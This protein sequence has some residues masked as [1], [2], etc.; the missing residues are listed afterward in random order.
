MVE[1]NWRVSRVTI[2]DK[3]LQLLLPKEVNP[4]SS[5]AKRSKTTGHLVVTMPLAGEV[6]KAAPRATAP[7][8]KFKSRL[9][10]KPAKT[11]RKE[12]E[13]E[14]LDIPDDAATKDLD[15][16]SI[17]DKD[18]PQNRGIYKRATAKVLEVEAGKNIFV[19][20]DLEKKTS[21]RKNSEGFVDNPDVP[22]LV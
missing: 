6:V 10:S 16:T 3:V 5:Q 18:N 8:P 1:A 19:E 4:D 12:L 22:P 2:K 21:E 11:R 20:S 9:V 17:C 15:Y 7:G 14:C 13:R